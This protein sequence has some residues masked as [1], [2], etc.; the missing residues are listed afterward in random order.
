LILLGAVLGLPAFAAG[1]NLPNV[2]EYGLYNFID[3][4]TETPSAIGTGITTGCDGVTYI[5]PP[6]PT[7]TDVPYV[8]EIML[9]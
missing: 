5:D 4:N 3:S 8:F 1:T 7:L 6:W 9:L 2:T